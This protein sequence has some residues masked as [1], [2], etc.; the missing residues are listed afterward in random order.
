[1]SVAGPNLNLSGITQY[2]TLT[3]DSNGNY[4]LGVAQVT[5]T[6]PGLTLTNPVNGVTPSMV[7]A[8]QISLPPTGMSGGTVTLTPPAGTNGI[9]FNNQ[10]PFFN[11]GSANLNTPAGGTGFLD[12][13]RGLSPFQNTANPLANVQPATGSAAQSTS[14]AQAQV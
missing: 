3:M 10:N 9:T 2:G 6:T 11:A 12:G 5:P 1:W 4:V 7:G 13:Y 8:P 14:A